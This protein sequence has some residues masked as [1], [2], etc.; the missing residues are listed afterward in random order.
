MRGIMTRQ[1]EAHQRLR[2]IRDEFDASH[3]A[4]RRAEARWDT[5]WDAT[6]IEYRKKVTLGQIRRAF[7]NLDRTFILR[8]FAEFEGILLAYWQDA[9]GRQTSPKIF[10]LI[11]RIGDSCPI[12]VS[13]A[14]RDATHE[15][16]RY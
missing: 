16:R 12:P 4:L 1:Q 7:D 11:N 10:V 15:I 5:E 14:Q 9:L 2:R 8:L 3:Y 13:S 6:T